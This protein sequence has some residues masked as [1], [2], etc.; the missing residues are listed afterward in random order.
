VIQIANQQRADSNDR[1]NKRKSEDSVKQ[2]TKDFW[3]KT[4]A[5]DQSGISVRDHCLN[6]S[7]VAEAVVNV[8]YAA[9]SGRRRE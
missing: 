9:V 2:G 1:L 5:D 3:A 7:A 4:T 6:V 8:R